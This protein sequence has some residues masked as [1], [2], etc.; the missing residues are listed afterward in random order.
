MKPMYPLVP[1]VDQWTRHAYMLA[2]LEEGYPR[3]VPQPIR[4][5]ESVSIACYGPSLQETWQEL[6]HPIISVSGAL[7]FLT[8]RGITPDY[9]VAMDPRLDAVPPI[10]PPVDGVHYLMA[11]VCHPKTW[12]VLRGQR[13]SQWHAIS[14]KTITPQWVQLKDPGMPVVTTGSNV[15]LGAIQIGGMLGYRHFEIHGMDG[16]CR[17]G[18]RH[19]G[20]HTGQKQKADITWDVQG[21]TYRTTKIMANGVAETMGA[22]QL[23]PIYGVF[24]GE[25]L[26]QALVRKR[27][28]VNACCAD[29]YHR[30]ESLRRGGVRFLEEVCR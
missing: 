28:Y 30:V 20:V 4:E 22:L 12:T 1:A 29:E 25:G 13:V 8:A 11:T 7:K 17:D 5:G 27:Q 9:H 23:Y 19:A 2:A 3:L 21:V 6:T 14:D 10:E 16:S 24:H 15:G 18:A 26:T